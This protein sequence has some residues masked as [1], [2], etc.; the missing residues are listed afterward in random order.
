MA[1]GI[2]L[3]AILGIDLD[4]S[5][6]YKS[7]QHAGY[8]KNL[9][10]GEM[11][12]DSSSGGE[13]Q[14]TGQVYT[15]GTS[16]FIYCGDLAVPEGQN[17]CI[18]FREF[19]DEN[20]AYVACWNSNGEHF[21]YRINGDGMACQIVYKRKGCLPFKLLPK[22][23]LPPFRW[24]MKTSCVFNNRTGKNE[25]EKYLI[26]CNG[27]RDFGYK[28]IPVEDSIAT[29]SF[30]E[31][32]F[33]Y[34]KTD[35][36]CCG[37]CNIINLNLP[38][39]YGCIGIT[40]VY[41][42]PPS[43]KTNL[44]V[45]KMF[46]WRIKYIDHWGR[47][48]EH[49]IISTGWYSAGGQCQASATGLPKCVRLKIPA[50]CP[51]WEKIQVEVQIQEAVEDS[52]APVASDWTLYDTFNKYTE[53]NDESPWYQRN[54]RSDD[55]IT[56]DPLTNTFS[57][58]FCNNKECKAIPITET[59]RLFN[60]LPDSGN[61]V[62]ALGNSI[63]TAGLE[64]GKEPLLCETLKKLK[65]EVIP[66]AADSGA[67]CDPKVR[68]VRIE[69]VIHNPIVD[70]NQPIWK[71]PEKEDVKVWGGLGQEIDP[72]NTVEF[73]NNTA[74]EYQQYILA[75]KTGFPGYFVGTSIVGYSKQY[76]VNPDRT[77]YNEDPFD[78]GGNNSKRRNI[79]GSIR[80]DYIRVQVWEF[81]NVPEGIQ[82]FRVG[83]HLGDTSLPDFDKSSTF[84]FGRVD[85]SVYRGYFQN[86]LVN[87]SKEIV[88]PCKGDYNN[89]KDENFFVLIHDLTRPK[90]A[91]STT[92]QRSAA[93]CGYVKDFNNNRVDLAAMKKLNGSY[94]GCTDHNGFY[95]ASEEGSGISR[96][97]WGKN[98]CAD[99]VLGLATKSGFGL[100]LQDINVTE[101]MTTCLANRIKATGQIKDCN[102]VGIQ[103]ITVMLTRSGYVKTDVNGR[104]TIIAHDTMIPGEPADRSIDKV[105]I[106]QNGICLLSICDAPCAI[107]ISPINAGFPACSSSCTE[108]VNNFFFPAFK[109][110]QGVSS[111]GIKA[112]AQ[113]NMAVIPQDCFSKDIWAENDDQHNLT[114]P[115]WQE[116]GVKGFST[117]RFSMPPDIV[118][119]LNVSYLTFARTKNLAYADYL[120]WVPNKI[121]Y[122][123]AAGN[124]APDNPQK[125][126]IYLNG[127]IE[128]NKLYNFKTNVQYQFLQG[129]R[130]EFICK[131]NGDLF[132]PNISLLITDSKDGD[133][134]ITDYDERLIGLK[135]GE[136]VQIIRANTC[137]N[138]NFYYEIC[139]IIKVVGGKPEVY[140][141][142]INTFDTYIFRRN[143]PYKVNDVLR[144]NSF[145]FPFEHHSPSD[146]WGNHCDDRGRVIVKNPFQRR[147]CFPT[148]I[149]ISNAFVL[150]NALNGIGRFSIDDYIV[151]DEQEWGGITA[152]FAQ[153]TT[154]LGICRNDNFVMSYSDDRLRLGANNT[155]M[156]NSGLFGRPERKIGNNFGCQPDDINT[157]REFQGHVW[158]IDGNKMALIEH[159]Y[160]KAEDVGVVALCSDYI[161]EKIQ[162]VRQ[163]NRDHPDTP[164]FFH[165]NFDPNF[166]KYHLTAFTLDPKNLSYGNDAREETIEINE[167]LAFN[168]WTKALDLFYA[169]TPEY[170][171]GL[172]GHIYDRQLISFKNGLP[173][174]HYRRNNPVQ[175]Y[176][177]YFG[178]QYG[179][180]YDVALNIE[181]NKVKRYLCNE[182]HCRQQLLFADRIL[183]EAGQESRLLIAL[184]ER[185][186]HFWASD[187]KMDLNTYP[188]PNI[189]VLLD[190]NKLIFEGNNLYGKWI[191]VRYVGIPG[192]NGI[193]FE[194]NG[195][196][197]FAIGSEKSGTAAGK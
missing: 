83:W 60:P 108:R 104:F 13:K 28:F 112:G 31:I 176:M 159:D 25:K 162:H 3:K 163:W 21:I 114:I 91:I 130:I 197:I 18:G 100:T 24:A 40:P 53:C 2:L 52:V 177:N 27:D 6:L 80:D 168:V 156:A 17:F 101:G 102:G 122:I 173:W 84:I 61:C 69:M 171:G 32:D 178:V 179:P 22:F 97:L 149:R 195:V 36:P 72:G 175:T 152:L 68:K 131:N 158:F 107:C 127:L 34:F 58:L 153:L 78:D 170:G 135:G 56:Y 86:Y 7:Q 146:L 128:Y 144:S 187:F 126:K 143:I 182:V 77:V 89:K 90:V 160:T 23:F 121:E 166:K 190:P 11:A 4:N 50:G 37:P 29:N 196:H 14:G 67:I 43:G 35:N 81:D 119:P 63:A 188:D 62:L 157:I 151:L 9:L 106:L 141:G 142:T 65:F 184:W 5:N 70:Q 116:T 55:S 51:T 117:I 134:I 85:V 95:F 132:P 79:V 136:L 99:V 109:L 118:F 123:D 8:I 73:E 185:R 10:I 105:Y 139:L 42:Q 1:I 92:K 39:P 66:P 76:L 167:T 191:R 16:N 193:Y 26:I 120:Q 46:K 15:P 194:F 71:S 137:A 124:L 88:I 44:M 174:L 111:S 133:Y 48:S 125:I 33:P 140:S 147:G 129:D 96:N 82:I 115:T 150:D 155:I 189:P 57:Y 59:S 47:P 192:N 110:I 113:I 41:E 164:K 180:V 181:A 103:G 54:V 169:F 74:G 165:G 98:T 93:I 138:R 87:G 161:A 75:G 30:N 172:F 148:K 154:V 186:E 183:T 145:P 45:N 38:F 19:E 94:Q 64:E 12:A 49:G 20:E